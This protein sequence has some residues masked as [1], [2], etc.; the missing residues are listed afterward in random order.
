M[1]SQS[2]KT[3]TVTAPVDIENETTPVVKRS[4]L[5]ASQY[6]VVL[7]QLSNLNPS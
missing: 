1:K 5:V 2:W 4:V 6:H 7:I 3:E